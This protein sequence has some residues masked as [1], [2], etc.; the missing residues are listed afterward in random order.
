MPKK[1]FESEKKT[2]RTTLGVTLIILFS[3]LCG[4]ARDIISAG[5]FGTGMDRDAYASAYTLLYVPVLLLSSCITSTVVPLY[6]S[7]TGRTGSRRTVLPPTAPRSSLGLLDLALIMLLLA[8]P[9]EVGGRG[10]DP[11]KQRLTAQLT[12]IMLP[13]LPF[14]VLSIVSPSVLNANERYKA[15]QLFGFP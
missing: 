13:S 15:G 8:E 4:F 11:E 7:E 2:V 3:K 14:V 10:F 6:V 5:Y 1:A 9:G 12:R